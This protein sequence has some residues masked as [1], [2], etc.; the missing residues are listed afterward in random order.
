MPDNFAR[1]LEKQI[2]EEFED[3][4]FKHGWRFLSSP[5]YV[6]DNSRVAFISLNPA[7]NSIITSHGQ[8]SMKSGSAFVNE[9][10]GNGITGESPL[11]IQVRKLFCLL[12]EDPENVLA[13]PLVPFRSP[14]WRDF[15]DHDNLKQRS[16]QFGKKIWSK[17]LK[18]SKPK[19]VI[20]IGTTIVRPIINDILNVSEEKGIDVNWGRIKGY[21]STFDGG[22]HV[23]LPHLSTFKI[24]GREESR[25][26][27]ERLFTGCLKHPQAKKTS[28]TRDLTFSHNQTRPTHSEKKSTNPINL[29]KKMP[30]PN[31]EHFKQHAKHIQN[32]KD[33]EIYWF[34]V[35]LA[36]ALKNFSC[37]VSYGGNKTDLLPCNVPDFKLGSVPR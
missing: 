28:I 22:I 6:L 30:Q 9:D 20:S 35:G 26:A 32:E 36:S 34:F 21:R 4:N 1:K 37:E 5:S 27:I 33:R 8:F 16:V 31:Y 14:R 3:G 25:E 11:Q 18:R 2:L 17:V 12:G 15:P 24:M 23:A 19:I 29:E 10:W 13:G 7:G